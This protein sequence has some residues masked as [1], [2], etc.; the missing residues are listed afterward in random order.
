MPGDGPWMGGAATTTTDALP[1]DVIDLTP[2]TI[3]NYRQPPP[4]D[5]PSTVSNLPAGGRIA[6]A[7]IPHIGL[8]LAI[9]DRLRRAAADDG[10]HRQR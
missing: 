8:G 1:F 10:S 9:N 7:P 3:A 5:R 2:T 4:I 6:V